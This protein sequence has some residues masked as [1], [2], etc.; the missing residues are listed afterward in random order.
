MRFQAKFSINIPGGIENAKGEHVSQIKSVAIVESAVNYGDAEYQ[1]GRM[2]Q[3]VY[4]GSTYLVDE[5]KKVKISDIVDVHLSTVTNDDW[6]WFVVD[7]SMMTFSDITGKDKM[8]SLGSTLVFAES[9]VDAIKRVS[10]TFP[11]T[12]DIHINKCQVTR[13]TDII[14]AE[15]DSG[16]DSVGPIFN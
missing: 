2:I 9:A 12:L 4:P 16:E 8:E 10:E 11:D 14:W 13:I 1:I 5:I 7:A 15:K 3:E 6:K